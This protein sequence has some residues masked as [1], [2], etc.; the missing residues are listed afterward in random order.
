MR[1][2]PF[3]SAAILAA[4][5]ALSG[6]GQNDGAP[7]A[8][9]NPEYVKAAG[10]MPDFAPLFPNA[11]VYSSI[12]NGTGPDAVGTVNFSTK[13][14]GEEVIEFYRSRAMAAGMVETTD[15]TDDAGTLTFSALKGDMGMKVIV[16]PGEGANNVQ[17]V[18]SRQSL[19]EDE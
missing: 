13:S 17:V 11:D 9:A 14:P 15:D 19:G 1:M 16:T 5:L 18:W 7:Q 8:A 4:G 12:G 10:L 6:C 2:R 3:F